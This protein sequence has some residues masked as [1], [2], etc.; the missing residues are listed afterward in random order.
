MVRTVPSAPLSKL[1]SESCSK[2]LG[3]LFNLIL[4]KITNDLK[5]VTQFRLVN[6]KITRKLISL[7]WEPAIK[8]VAYAKLDAIRKKIFYEINLNY[9]Q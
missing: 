1:L 4:E 6:K 2:K 7:F 3:F 5:F 9:A 8:M